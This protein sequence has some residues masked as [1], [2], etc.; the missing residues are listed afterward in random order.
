MRLAKSDRAVS[1]VRIWNAFARRLAKKAG[2]SSSRI[3]EGAV[4]GQVLSAEQRAGRPTRTTTARRQLRQSRAGRR[5]YLRALWKALKI[6]RKSGASAALSLYFLRKAALRWKG[7]VG[8]GKRY[9]FKNDPAT[10]SNPK[11]ANCPKGCP[12]AITMCPRSR[13]NNCYKSDMPGN[14]FYAHI[15]R[16][17]GFSRLA[18]QLGSQYAHLSASRRWDPPEDTA[19]VN[20]GYNLPR[21]LTRQALCTRLWTSSAGFIKPSCRQCRENSKARLR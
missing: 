9:D 14:L 20:F 8:T 10:M 15:G 12:G 7:L 18:L 2:L 19:M 5:E 13:G 3:L 1:Q 6:H 11:S 17:A 16:F 4:R 21:K